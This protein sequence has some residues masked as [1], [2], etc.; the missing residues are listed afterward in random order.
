M[1]ERIVEVEWVDS[2]TV[3]GWHHAED[4]PGVDPIVSVGHLH[5][6]DDNELV[7]V[8][9]INLAVDGPRVRTAKLSESLVIPRS[10]IRKVTELKRGR[11]N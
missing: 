11:R 10:A 2:T 8:Q 4:I 1:S 3:N 9:S 5:R 6:E 7:L